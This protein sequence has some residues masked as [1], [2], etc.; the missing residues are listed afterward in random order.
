[1]KQFGLTAEAHIFT[2]TANDQNFELGMER[3]IFV[4]DDRREIAVESPQFLLHTS[5]ELWN[6]WLRRSV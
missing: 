5:I 4:H 3:K 1:M 2:V 6:T